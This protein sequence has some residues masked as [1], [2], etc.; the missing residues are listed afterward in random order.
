M[1]VLVGVPSEPCVQ[2]HGDA[3]CRRNRIAGKQAAE[4]DNVEAIV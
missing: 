1:L 4:V 3:A 2:A